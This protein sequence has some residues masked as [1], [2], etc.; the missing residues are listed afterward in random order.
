MKTEFNIGDTLHTLDMSCWPPK[1]ITFK[2]ER[3]KIAEYIIYYDD[4]DFGTGHSEIKCAKSKAE[5]HKKFD[6][7]V[8]AVRKCINAGPKKKKKK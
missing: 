4:P 2:V 3:I 5:L 7:Q 6:A 8:E 1:Y